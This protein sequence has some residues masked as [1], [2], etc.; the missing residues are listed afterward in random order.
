M[1]TLLVTISLPP[2]ALSP[3]ARPHWAAKAKAAKAHRGESFLMTGQAIKGVDKG[4]QRWAKVGTEVMVRVTFWHRV[5]RRRDRDNAQ[6]SLKAA[7]D[8]IAAAL[9]VD[10]SQFWHAPLEMKVDRDKPRVE[11]E[12]TAKHRSG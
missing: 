11:V 9:G 3:N 5:A 4:G 10:D 2:K 7:F 12:L 6:A 1:S 8:G